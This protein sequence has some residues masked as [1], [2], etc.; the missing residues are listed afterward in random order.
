MRPFTALAALCGLFLSSSNSL[1][2]ADSTPSSSPVALPRDFKPPQVFKNNNLVRN[3]NLEKG[4]LRETVNVVVENV[5]KKPQSDYYLSFPSDLYDKVGALEVRDKSAPEQGRFEVEAT[6]FDSNRDFQY[7]VVHLPKPLAPSSQI[8]LGISYSA[9]NTLKPRPAAISQTDRQYLAYAFSAY[10]PSAYTTA[11]QKTKIKFPSTNVPDYTTTDLTSGA[12]PERQ[13]ATYTYGPYADVA[14]ETT[15][16][17]SVRYEFTK[18]VITATL[19]E[20]DLEVSHWGGNLATEERYWLRNNGSKL[21]DNFNRVEWTISS[22]QQLPS[23]A[24]R[25]L[26]IPLKPGS[27]DPYFTDD[28]GNVSTSRYRPGKV[29]NRDASL[30]LRPRFPIFG[31][32]NYSFRIGWNNDLSAFLRKAVTG[33]DSYVLKVPFIEGPKVPEGIQYEKAVVRIILPEGARNVRYELLEKA[34]SNGLPGANQIQT[35]LTSHKTFM[36]T[37]GRTALTLTVEELTDEARDSQIVITYDYSLWDGLRKP[38]TITAG[39]FTVFVAA[40][41]IGNIDVS[42]KKR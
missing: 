2:Y 12:D 39:L 9:L 3:T 4:Y 6:E 20:R 14:P 28:I 31:G 7:F 18:P 35:E 29:P 42:I 32:W 33:A 26:K 25:E 21:T 13:G 36:D 30:E 17:A 1:V 15:Y 19:L 24:I 37:L 8:T 27:V 41:A 5:D 38:V 16:P 34:T 23:S 11:T 40:W 10:A 22:Y